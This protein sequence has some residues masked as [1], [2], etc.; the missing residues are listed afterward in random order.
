MKKTLLAIP[1]LI[2]S[3]HAATLI[4]DDFS[5]DGTAGL[6][7]TSPDTNTLSS[8]T[9]V[10]S[11]IIANNGQV[12]DGDNTDR[13]A[14]IDLGAG[15]AFQ[16][17]QTYTLTVGWSNLSS[18]ILFAGFS[19]VAQNVE[20]AMQVQPDNFA[21]RIRALTPDAGIAAWTRI[22]AVNSPTLGS[23]ANPTGAG[24]TTM[25]ITTNSLTDATFAVDG[26]ASTAIDLT[27]YRYLYLGYEEGAGGTQDA[28]FTSV[29]FALVPEPTAALLGS[30]GL[31][32]L[33]RRRR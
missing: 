14:T 24:T 8:A 29:E 5:G 7:D 20:A 9:W 25:T 18:A 11:T 12:N 33:L 10:A 4:H 26:V 32:A 3:S 23:T 6:H 27:G 2:A 13:G 30:L 31:L 15:F 17:N 28:R 21:V 1:L 19:T 16:A 22:G